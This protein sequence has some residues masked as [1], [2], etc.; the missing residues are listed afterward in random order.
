[1]LSYCLKCRKN[2]ES[3]NPKVERTKNRR[4]VLLSKC[5]EFNSKRSKFLKEQEAKELLSS[6][7]I[8]TPLSQ[9]PLL[10]QLL[11]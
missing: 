3:K 9:I 2:T 1:M 11:F 7:G 10:G 8:R 4:I 5:V 6:I